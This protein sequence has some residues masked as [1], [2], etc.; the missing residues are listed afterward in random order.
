[1]NFLG[2]FW[3]SAS[4]PCPVNGRCFEIASTFLMCLKNKEIQSIVHAVLVLDVACGWWN[5]E[6]LNRLLDTSIVNSRRIALAIRV[7]V[8]LRR[9]AWDFHTRGLP[10]VMSDR[11]FALRITKYEEIWNSQFKNIKKRQGFSLV[12]NNHAD[13]TEHFALRITKYQEFWNSQFK[14]IKKRQG[15]SLVLNNHPDV[16]FKNIKKRQGFS[17]VLNSHPDVTEHFC[18]TYNEISR[19]LKFRVQKY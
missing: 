4:S 13:V 7:L 2:E 19:I 12:L 15:F 9:T 8:D 10:S 6:F 5:R 1:M 14:N 3:K 17:L 18:S 11:F 16:T